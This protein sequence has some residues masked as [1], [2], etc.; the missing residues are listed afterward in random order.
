MLES[1]EANM[2]IQEACKDED[3]TIL[4]VVT[5]GSISIST[6]DKEFATGLSARELASVEHGLAILC[7]F[8][9][10]KQVV[11][12][13]TYIVTKKGYDYADSLVPQK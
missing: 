7:Q 4:R 10:L 8:E 5:I 6:N 3:G 13:Q 2:L 11:F 9:Y 12:D 1:N